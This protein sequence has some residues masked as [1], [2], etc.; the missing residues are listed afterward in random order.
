MHRLVFREAGAVQ[1][2]GPAIGEAGGEVSACLAGIWR[3]MPEARPPP[4]RLASASKEAVASVTLAT[5]TAREVIREVIFSRCMF[6]F[7]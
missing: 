3:C 1:L 7:G 5:A 4:R 2:R 6:S